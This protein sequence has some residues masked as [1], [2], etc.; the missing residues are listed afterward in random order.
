MASKTT[1]SCLN[2]QI[3]S[4]NVCECVL[5]SDVQQESRKIRTLPHLICTRRLSRVLAQMRPSE[6]LWEGEQRHR[7]PKRQVKYVNEMEKPWS[8]LAHSFWN[9]SGFCSMKRLG[10]F[11]LPLPPICKPAE[12]ACPICKIEME[13][14]EKRKKR[15]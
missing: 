10:T 11:L 15:I 13:K 1:K 2:L 7:H 12:R 8:R 9:L 6:I 14:K 4:N 3:S 5:I